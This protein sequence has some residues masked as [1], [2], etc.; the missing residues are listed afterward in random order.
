M[1]GWLQVQFSELSAAQDV[2]HEG[3]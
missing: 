2:L 1:P 3:L